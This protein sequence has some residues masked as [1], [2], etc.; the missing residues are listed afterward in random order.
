MALKRQNTHRTVSRG[1]FQSNRRFEFAAT[2]LFVPAIEKHNMAP[3]RMQRIEPAQPINRAAPSSYL[4]TATAEEQSKNGEKKAF[5]QVR[6][7][8]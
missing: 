7:Y 4:Q 2:D 8:F 3:P 1:G 5:F 6:S